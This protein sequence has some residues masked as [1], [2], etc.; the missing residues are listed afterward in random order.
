VGNSGGR[1]RAARASKMALPVAG[2]AGVIA[3]AGAVVVALT[4]TLSASPELL[5][6]VYY[7]PGTKT[8]YVRSPAVYEKFADAMIVG[9]GVDTTGDTKQYVDYPGAFWPVSQGG[10]SAPTFDDS[11]GI[12]LHHLESHN[13]TDGDV[14]F[15]YS[16]GAVV[17]AKYKAEHPEQTGIT[18][19]LVE[20]PNRPNGGVLERFNG[21]FIPILNVTFNGAT[22]NTGPIGANTVDISRQY[23]GW[24][25]FPTYPLNLLADANAIAGI[26]YLHGNTQ[27][28]TDPAVLAALKAE[29]NPLYY[30][31]DTA[32]NTTYYV[33]PTTELPILMLFNGIV[34]KPVLDALDPPLRAL[35]ELGYDRSDYGTPTPAKLLPAVKGGATGLAESAS[36]VPA[37]TP[38]VTANSVAAPAVSAAPEPDAPKPA[39]PRRPT[40]KASPPSS[41]ANKTGVTAP[42]GTSTIQSALKALSPKNL[43]AKRTGAKKPTPA[44]AAAD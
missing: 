30:Q 17:A 32:T 19:V 18:Y 7:L 1:H 12:G 10:L 29:G 16:Q 27:D 34:P 5:G 28:I 8:G 21:L 35:I 14:I 4:P 31:E 37:V 24:S 39:T 33:I 15:G 22:P 11:V 2:A 13:P 43:A 40:G 9:G 26:V 42:T 36:P 20:N 6:N 3:M 25:D 41:L 44:A 23:D 38:S